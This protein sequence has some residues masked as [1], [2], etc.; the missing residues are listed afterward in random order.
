M[1]RV[2]NTPAE[3]A[4]RFMRAFA[5]LDALYRSCL[6]DGLLVAAVDTD[7]DIVAYLHVPVDLEPVFA[8]V[9][10]HSRCDLALAGPEVSLRHAVLSARRLGLDE[11]RVRLWVLHGGSAVTTEAGVACEALIADGPLFVGLAGFILFCL[12][13]GTLAPVPWSGGADEVWAC[14]PERVIQDARHPLRQPARSS[15]LDARG[16]TLVVPGPAALRSRATGPAAGEPAGTLRVAVDAERIVVEVTS[17]DLRRGL[18]IGRD[19]RCA[20]TARLEGISRLHLLLV[21]EQGDV[22]A[23]DTASTNGTTLAGVG[24]RQ[25]LLDGHR[26]LVLGERVSIRW[27]ARPAA[28]P[29]RDELL[30]RFAAARLAVP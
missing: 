13:T 4:R 7:G 25:A 14:L 28:G 20:L 17:H 22:W 12:P 19:E 30:A 3:V 16:G 2:G 26:E 21:E 18:L 27:S 6:A 10:R 23:I 24:V 11:V 5:P 29:P 15:G 1:Q 8:V 9:G